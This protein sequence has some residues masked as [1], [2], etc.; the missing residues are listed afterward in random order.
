MRVLFTFLFVLASQPLVAEETDVVEATEVV[1]AGAC[2]SMIEGAIIF[3][4]QLPEGQEM[5]PAAKA[6]NV[7]PLCSDLTLTTCNVAADPALCL[8]TISGEIIAFGLE[9]RMALRGLQYDNRF[10]QARMDRWLEEDTND[11]SADA[12]QRCETPDPYMVLLVDAYFEGLLLEDAC[13]AMYI[14]A[15]ELLMAIQARRVA[16]RQGVF[17]LPTVSE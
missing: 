13:M 15:D 2:I 11:I 14:I 9:S 17:A 7:T 16:Y 3:E 1:V 4:A 6:V 12:K 10:S 5:D 8:S